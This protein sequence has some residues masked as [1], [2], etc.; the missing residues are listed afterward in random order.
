MHLAAR[1]GGA[2]HAIEGDVVPEFS[3]YYVAATL[4]ANMVHFIFQYIYIIK[5][6]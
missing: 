6:I 2:L 3:V 5:N 4:N 1:E